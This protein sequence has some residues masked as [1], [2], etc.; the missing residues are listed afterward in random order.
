MKRGRINPMMS[1]MTMTNAKI[2]S[3]LIALLL[4]AAGWRA[5]AQA[6]SPTAALMMKDDRNMHM[7]AVEALVVEVNEERTRDL[8]ISYSGNHAQTG[9]NGV[10]PN[11]DSFIQGGLVQLGQ[12]LSPVNVPTLIQGP[13]GTNQIGFAQ[14]LPGLGFSLTGMNIGTAQLSAKIRMLLDSGD[15]TIRTRPVAVAMNNTPVRIETVNEVPV[16][17]VMGGGQLNVEFRKVGVLME[18]TPAIENL[19]QKMVT[20]N[21]NKLEVSSVS[22]LL[23]TRN[24]DRPVFA[25]SA[26]QQTKITLSA[27]ETFLF[28]GLKTRRTDH[29]EERVPILGSIPLIKYFFSS[30]HDIERHLDVLFFITPYIVAPGENILL[31]FDFKNQKALGVETDLAQR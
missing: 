26:A 24:V 5:S 12:T 20:L 9:P 3:L 4:A 14:R 15:A 11:N 19:R 21:V 10:T 23:T 22:T 17:T 27:G 2:K 13:D 31:P 30:Q 29:T 25:K 1:M 8:G 18:V 16:Q 28:G 6:P 7:V